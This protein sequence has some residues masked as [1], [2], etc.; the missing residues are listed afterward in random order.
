MTIRFVTVTQDNL[1][2]LRRE[3]GDVVFYA[4]KHSRKDGSSS[5]YPSLLPV[6]VCK[7]DA[8]LVVRKASTNIHR[9]CDAGVNVSTLYWQVWHYK[10]RCHILWLVA[11]R[12]EDIACI[13]TDSDGK[14]R[15][16]RCRVVRKATKEELKE[17]KEL[18]KIMVPL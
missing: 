3:K 15:L 16:F 13:P 10:H 1:Q 12:K 5:F 4:Y 7:P 6:L 18:R 8:E 9:R 14:F 11:F 17:L 2:K